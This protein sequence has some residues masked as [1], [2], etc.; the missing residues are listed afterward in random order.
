[1]KEILTKFLNKVSKFIINLTIKLNKEGAKLLLKKSPRSL[2][3]TP[4]KDLFWLNN[5]GYLDR[6]IIDTGVF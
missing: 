6:C 1:M 4:K 5:T 2:Y 3:C